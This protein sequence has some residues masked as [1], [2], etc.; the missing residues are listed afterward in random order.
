MFSVFFLL[1]SVWQDRK[2]EPF[3]FK[4]IS[5]TGIKICWVF[6]CLLFARRGKAG[7]G[8]GDW[9][10]RGRLVN[11]LPGKFQFSHQL[12]EICRASKSSCGELEEVVSGHQT[13]SGQTSEHHPIWQLPTAVAPQPYLDQMLSVW[14]I[15]TLS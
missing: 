8:D 1:L 7:K 4:F 5:N 9:N 2:K 10:I 14:G 11:Y 6:F 13:Q 15:P 12:H 3:C